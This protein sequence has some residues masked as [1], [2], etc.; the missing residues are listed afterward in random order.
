MKET[1]LYQP[2]KSFLEASGYMVKAEITSADVV[3]IKD[4]YIVIVEL[5]TQ[6]FVKVDLS[7]NRKTKKSLIRFTFVYP[8]VSLI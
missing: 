1:D 3:G 2:V 6:Y 4:D 5:K 7:S 8:E